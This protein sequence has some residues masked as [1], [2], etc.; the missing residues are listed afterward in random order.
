M[1]K[2]KKRFSV[3]LV[4]TFHPRM[5]ASLVEEARR[6]DVSVRSLIRE[7]VGEGLWQ[8]HY[9]ENGTRR[10]QPVEATEG[11]VII[12]LPVKREGA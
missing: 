6:R 11:A 10:R 8:A 4:A 2:V 12:P 7:Y 1:P 5:H 9:G 3:S